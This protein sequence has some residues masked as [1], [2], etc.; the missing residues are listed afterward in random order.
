MTTTGMLVRLAET[1]PGPADSEVCVGRVHLWGRRVWMAFRRD[2]VE[3]A[4][5]ARGDIDAVTDLGIL[6]V[7]M[8]LPGGMPVPVA[9]LPRADYRVLRQAPNG[10]VQYQA[11]MVVR[12]LIP[13][14]TPV[15]AVVPA[16][17]W[18]QGAGTASRFAVYCPRM[19]LLPRP[20][21]EEA[22]TLSEASLYGIGVAVSSGADPARVL[23]EP[24]VSGTWQPS[25]AGWGFSEKIYA[26][27]RERLR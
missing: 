5:R 1:V 23:V 7:L 26:Q 3:W 10:V 8:N 20:P 2:A 13:V 16:R 18:A 11:D 17:T 12:D 4:R 14:L 27:V 19:V 22:L 25:V 9:C 24:E 15:L 6:D 21:N